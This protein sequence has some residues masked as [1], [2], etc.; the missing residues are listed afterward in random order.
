MLRRPTE[1][2]FPLNDA[3]NED[4]IKKNKKRKPLGAINLRLT[5]SPV[6]KEE[7]NEVRT[8]ESL[9]RPKFHAD[10]VNCF[11]MVTP[12]LSLSG[13]QTTISDYES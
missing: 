5:M 13:S 3:C 9:R 12:N 11:L 10:D 2:S 7:M 1:L 6:S 4:L 8:G